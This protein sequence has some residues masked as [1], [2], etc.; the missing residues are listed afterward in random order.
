MC[1]ERHDRN[2]S[3]YFSKPVVVPEDG[4]ARFLLQRLCG[5][6]GGVMVVSKEGEVKM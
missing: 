1:G 5:A 6:V 4:F 3:A 2:A